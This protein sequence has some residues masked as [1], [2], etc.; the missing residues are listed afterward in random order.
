[1]TTKQLTREQIRLL[2][3]L[4]KLV[5]AIDPYCYIVMGFGRNYDREEYVSNEKGF[6]ENAAILCVAAAAHTIITTSL[7]RRALSATVA[8]PLE[9]APMRI[10]SLKSL[11]P[12]NRM[13]KFRAR[14]E[15]P[16]AAKAAPTRKRTAATRSSAMTETGA[17]K[18]T[19]VE[20]EAL[21]EAKLDEMEGDL[22]D[23][24]AEV[25]APTE[26]QIDEWVEGRLEELQEELEVQAAEQLQPT[27]EAI[28]RYVERRREE[29][30]WSIREQLTA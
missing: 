25:L 10:G 5:K 24:A 19:E 4:I 12:I 9:I 30:Y 22:E 29:L 23:E 27:Q 1:M 28:E 20:L 16:K 18:P 6:E 3:K 8:F 15:P 26:G 17:R 14:I 21:I 7:M 11:E 13:K 2:K